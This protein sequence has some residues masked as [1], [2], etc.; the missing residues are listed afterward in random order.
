MSGYTDN[1]CALSKPTTLLVMNN[2]LYN[3]L[4]HL[5]RGDDLITSGVNGLIHSWQTS[6]QVIGKLCTSHAERW[7]ATIRRIQAPVSLAEVL[8]TRSS[9]WS[10]T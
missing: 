3:T 7:Q 6:T 10:D 5:Q 1:C 4:Q 9:C 8:R 2:L